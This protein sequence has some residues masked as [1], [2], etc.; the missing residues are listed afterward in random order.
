MIEISLDG[1][2]KRQQVLAEIIWN[3]DEWDQVQTFINSLSKRD[4]IDCEGIIE[5]MRLS[6]VEQYADEMRKDGLIKDQ[7]KQANDVIGKIRSRKW[8]K[9]PEPFG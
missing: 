2:S 8:K 4:R 9:S 3:I 1:L 5:M 7:Y 6:L